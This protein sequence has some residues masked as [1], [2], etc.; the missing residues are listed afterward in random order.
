MP[1]KTCGVIGVDITLLTKD[2]KVS[3]TMQVQFKE[4]VDL[5]TKGNL[6]DQTQTGN[7]LIAILSK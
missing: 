4:T 5:E 2:N 3:L 6:S 7:D 1:N